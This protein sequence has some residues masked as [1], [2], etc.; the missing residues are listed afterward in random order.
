MASVGEKMVVD[1]L[2]TL[3][4]MSFWREFVGMDMRVGARMMHGYGLP[5]VDARISGILLNL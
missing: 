3:F 4:D 2:Q 1:V 5:L